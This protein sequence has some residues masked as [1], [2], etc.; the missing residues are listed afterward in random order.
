VKLVTYNFSIKY[1]TFEVLISLPF[2]HYN[3]VKKKLDED[4]SMLFDADYMDMQTLDHISRKWDLLDV[5]RDGNGFKTS[6]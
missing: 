2:A 1:S 4:K 6:G 3:V 5:A